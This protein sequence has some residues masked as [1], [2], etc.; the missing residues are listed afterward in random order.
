MTA[1]AVMLVAIAQPDGRVPKWEKFVTVTSDNVN[2]RKGPGTN[3]GKLYYD[4]TLYKRIEYAFVAKKGYKV[5]HP[6][7]SDIFPVIDETVDWYHIYINYDVEAYVSKQFACEIYPRGYVRFYPAQ[8]GG[9]FSMTAIQAPSYGWEAFFGVKWGLGELSMNYV[10]NFDELHSQLGEK[11]IWQLNSEKAT[12]DFIRNFISTH[13]PGVEYEFHDSE[14]G[15]PYMLT[16]NFGPWWDSKPVSF[17]YDP[18][19]YKHEMV[20][21][22]PEPIIITSF[23][24]ARTGNSLHLLEKPQVGSKKLVWVEDENDESGG[25][26]AGGWL[27]WDNPKRKRS[28]VSDYDIPVMAV[29]GEEGDYYKVYHN[30]NFWGTHDQYMG[31]VAKADCEIAVL[32]KFSIEDLKGIYGNAAMIGN[33]FVAWGTSDEDYCDVITAGFVT[34]NLVAI[35]HSKNSYTEDGYIAKVKIGEFDDDIEMRG[36]NNFMNNEWG[37]KIPNFAKLPANDLA[38]LTND[39]MPIV[40]AYLKFDN[41]FGLFFLDLSGYHCHETSLNLNG[42]PSLPVTKKPDVKASYDNTK[43]NNIKH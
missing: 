29:I 43:S 3:Y 37:A 12:D 31:Y 6:S 7:T 16:Y 17:G 38:R 36:S 22:S 27:E 13:K 32:Q 34:G 20:T 24:K 1:I 35:Q 21:S 14:F 33:R 30:A 11:D 9:H 28:L 19:K 25:D 2:L 8:P 42:S 15:W 40:G 18:D 5:Y 26:G 10:K 41:I 23:V 39:K 4:D